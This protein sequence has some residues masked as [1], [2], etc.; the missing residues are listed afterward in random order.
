V[1]IQAV[2]RGHHVRR[3]LRHALD[4]AKYMGDDDDDD[5]VGVDENEFALPGDLDSVWVPDMRK[6]T[7]LDSIDDV[8]TEEPPRAA[9]VPQQ[10][11]RAADSGEGGGRGRPA[12]RGRDVTEAWEAPTEEHGQET[13]PVFPSVQTPP[14]EQ[15]PLASAP[16]Q[17]PGSARSAHNDRVAGLFQRMQA[18][19][20]EVVNEWG[21]TNPATIEAMKKKSRKYRRHEQKAKRK[22]ATAAQRFN[23]LRSANS[24]AQSGWSDVGSVR[25][26]P[27]PSPTPPAS[28][29]SD[30]RV[31]STLVR[32][33]GSVPPSPATSQS[34]EPG[35]LQHFSS[36]QPNLRASRELASRGSSGSRERT[37]VAQTNNFMQP[38]PA[39]AA[40]APA[41]APWGM[42]AQGGS[43][44]VGPGAGK[45]R[46]KGR[47]KVRVPRVAGMAR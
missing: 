32:R 37:P 20:E 7:E 26:T 35:G 44:V 45:K 16:E 38:A 21:L 11:A 2:F 4:S 43:M 36:G 18:K 27:S 41:P 9:A 47:S 10:P 15:E 5:F 24:T 1:R 30:T 14:R 3:R 6:S 25:S 8:A 34:S 13:S 42:A 12:A 17:E 19:E 31:P 28:A 46:K 29:R 23:H 33:I 22:N 40:A 39:A